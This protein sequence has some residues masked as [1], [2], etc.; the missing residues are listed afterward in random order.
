MKT[1][2]I[3]F[4]STAG[5]TAR[6]AEAV[7]AGARSVEGVQAQLIAI[8]ANDI[9]KG[10]YK[11][12]EVMAQLDASDAIILGSPTYMGGPAAQF[13]AFADASSERWYGQQWR[14]KLAA[15]FTVSGTLSGDKYHTLQYLHALAMQHGMIWVGLGEL[16][17]Q[18]NGVN[19][20]GSWIGAM[21]VSGH[22]PSDGTPGADDL[23]T[24]EVLGRRV[25]TVALR[26]N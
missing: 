19:R 24:G 23:L 9:V 17:A 3:L 18:E 26:L 21:G 20:L 4:Y 10:R 16:P 25:A 8:D 11:N 13:K 14:D 5:H 15:G 1:V 2:S 6:M 7:A 12:P 22:E